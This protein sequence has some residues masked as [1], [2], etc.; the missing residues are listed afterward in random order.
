MKSKSSRTV[1]APPTAGPAA[2]EPPAI[3]S[4][5]C[6]LNGKQWRLMKGDCIEL[7]PTLPAKCVDF[8]V[9][10]PPFPSVYAYTSEAA[11]IGNSEDLNTEAKLHL[12]WFYRQL[13]RVMKPG[14]VVCVHVQ[15]IVRMK[16]AGE[17]GL[18]D[19]RGFNI[20][21]AERAGLIFEQD[22]PI[23]KNPQAQAI[24]TK[25]REL[26]FAGLER[27]R[28][29]SR[30]SLPDYILKFVAPGENAVRIDN[31]EV[32][33]SEWIE[34][35]EGVWTWHEIKATDTLNTTEAKGPD[36]T[37]HICPL[38][39][40]AIER[41]VR[42]YSQPGE[43]VFSPFAGV[44]SEGFESVKRGR[45]FIGFE[46][47]DEYYRTAIKNLARAEKLKVEADKTLF[48]ELEAVT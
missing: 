44:G 6:L 48:D 28:A 24:R 45:R 31:K 16:R 32:S 9:F 21:I 47:K 17:Q 12:S 15:Q 3:T 27:D 39:L 2:S 5:D 19:F 11:D 33:R 34:W 46:L 22:I 40:G 7:M 38:Q 8:S 35:A 14:R 20:R 43:V 10:S 18:F 36:D 30:P 1:S 4:A 23:T 42:L 25:S 41:L 26:Q 13:A 37:K 29:R